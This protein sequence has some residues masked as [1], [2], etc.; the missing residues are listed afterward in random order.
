[1]AVTAVMI[2][3]KT[4]ATARQQQWLQQKNNNNNDDNNKEEEAELEDNCDDNVIKWHLII[5]TE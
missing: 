4:A 5:I 1:M 3:M 2:T